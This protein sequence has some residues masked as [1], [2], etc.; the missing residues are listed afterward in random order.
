MADELKDKPALAVA[1]EP[2]GPEPEPRPPFFT[3]TVTGQDTYNLE[4]NMADYYKW[5]IL[6]LAAMIR[7]EVGGG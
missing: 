6:K 5:H 2:V 7:K 1:P 4:T 3:V